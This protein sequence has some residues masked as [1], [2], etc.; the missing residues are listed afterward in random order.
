MPRFAKKSSITDSFSY[1]ICSLLSSNRK[2]SANNSHASFAN[3]SNRSIIAAERLADASLWASPCA[4]CRAPAALAHSV[5]MPLPSRR[6]ANNPCGVRLF[7][8]CVGATV[9]RPRACNARPYKIKYK[10]LDTSFSRNAKVMC[11]IFY[12]RTAAPMV[13]R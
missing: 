5:K 3:T 12:K 10:K 4:P 11:P 13:R 6:R 7:E 9:G 8:A 1:H 2:L